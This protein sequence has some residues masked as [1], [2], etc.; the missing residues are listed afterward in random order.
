[1]DRREFVGILGALPLLGAARA[2]SPANFSKVVYP[3]K[4]GRLVYV[5]D[6]EG[7]TIPD[8]SNCGYMGGG[9]KLPSVPIRATV[10]PT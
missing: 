2:F 3:G 5:P 7:N 1:M 6:G 9:V 8:F 4:D 10:E